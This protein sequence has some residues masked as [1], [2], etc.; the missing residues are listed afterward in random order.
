MLTH[1]L[2]EN[3][4]KKLVAVAYVDCV[5]ELLCGNSHR[6]AVLWIVDARV[7]SG[8]RSQFVQQRQHARHAALE[9]IQ[10]HAVARRA[11]SSQNTV[12]GRQRSNAPYV[13]SGVAIT[14]P[15]ENGNECV[16]RVTLVISTNGKMSLR[17]LNEKAAVNQSALHT[18]GLRRREAHE[19]AADV[20]GAL[21]AAQRI[22]AQRAR[23][24]G[25]QIVGLHSEQLAE[26]AVL[27]V[28]KL[29]L[30]RRRRR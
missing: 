5:D 13:L 30:R 22:V 8:T 18:I 16:L 25:N 15:L 4:K 28:V 24:R 11:I 21:I 27:L 26:V 6:R 7:A 23:K 29:D 20:D 17:L 12:F 9:R 19:A 3:R 10:F 2:E 1:P 14:T